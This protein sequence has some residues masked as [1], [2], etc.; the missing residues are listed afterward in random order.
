M[1][2]KLVHSLISLALLFNVGFVLAP[3]TVSAA[4]ILSDACQSAPDSEACK[5]RT[6]TNPITG[7]NGLLFKVSATI[8]TFAG[9]VAVIVVIISGFRYMTSNGDSQKTA[10]AKNALIGALV[11]LAIIALAQTIIAFVVGRL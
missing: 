1:K 2:R 8:A 11:G 3:A 10:S 4:D 9:I 5:S 7:P 6:T